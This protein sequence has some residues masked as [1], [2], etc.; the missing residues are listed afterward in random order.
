MEG[1][2]LSAFFRKALQTAATS[3]RFVL[4]SGA[5]VLIPDDSF[6]ETILE[7]FK[8][9]REEFERVFK[10]LAK[11][12]L[13]LW[14]TTNIVDWKRNRKTIQVDG[15][16]YTVTE[17]GYGTFIH[18]KGFIS[19][20]ALNRKFEN[21]QKALLM[22]RE[23]KK[24]PVGHILPH[25]DLSRT[26]VTDDLRGKELI[27]KCNLS[28]EINRECNKNNYQLFKERLLTEFGVNF[29]EDSHGFPDAR[30]LYMQMHEIFGLSRVYR[31]FTDEMKISAYGAAISENLRY[32]TT[33]LDIK[34]GKLWLPP[35][36][37]DKKGN[38]SP[39]KEF[40]VIIHTFDLPS[41]RSFLIEGLEGRSKD[42][43]IDYDGN[44]PVLAKFFKEDGWRLT[45]KFV[46]EASMTGE[47]HTIL[48]RKP[49]GTVT[50]V[51]KLY[52]IAKFGT[53]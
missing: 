11:E 37:P 40:F 44:D 5:S 31:E 7:H 52:R 17:G 4:P 34:E 22:Q 32:G 45:E 28:A 13:A 15:M 21:A 18:Y 14:T 48:N 10:T 30:K 43:R 42:V 3:T 49:N 39:V 19:T 41:S 46:R 36:R 8:L 38:W 47:F 29:N 51:A 53:V 24:N 16:R 23:N 26:I 50:Q 6:E 12:Y 2:S 27:K 35:Y 9:P 33:P 1:K 20:D 25:K